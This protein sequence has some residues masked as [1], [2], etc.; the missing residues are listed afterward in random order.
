MPE[1]IES[2]RSKESS[3]KAMV[4]RFLRQVDRRVS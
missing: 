4:D 2:T 3:T 1:N